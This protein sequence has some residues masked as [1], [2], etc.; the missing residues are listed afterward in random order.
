[1]P[2]SETQSR[3]KSVELFYNDLAPTYDHEQFQTAVSIS[4]RKEY[5][6]FSARLPE[7]FAGA[8]RVLEIGAGTG[9]F[10]IPIAR[11]CREVI[12]VDISPNMLGLLEKKA[13]GEGVINIRTILCDVEKSPPEGTFSVICAFASFEYIAD[14]PGLLRRLAPHLEP[15]GVIYFITARRSFLRFFTQFGNAVRQ[16]MWLKAHS[17]AEIR[18]MLRAAGYLQ[19][20]INSHLFKVFSYGGMLLEVVA[21]RAADSN[22]SAAYTEEL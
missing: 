20:E 3:S 10:T 1:M 5:E 9:I 19:I 22:G 8:E 13:A 2:H 16:G 7:L 18:A 4:K 11:H 17:R 15:G 14:L 12:A 6:L 21:R